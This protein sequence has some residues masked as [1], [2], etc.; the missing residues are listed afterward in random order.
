M[1]LMKQGWL[2][3]VGFSFFGLLIVFFLL[4]KA[5]VSALVAGG[6]GV[7]PANPDPAKPLTQSWFIYELDPGETKEDAVR[8]INN[9]EQTVKLHIDALDGGISQDGGFGIIDDPKNNVD[10]GS[11]IT[12]SETEVTLPPRKEKV[13]KF[14]LTVPSDTYVGDHFGGFGVYQIEEA[15]EQEIKV[16]P[17]ATVKVK[18]RV[19]VRMY[20]TVRGEKI[21]GLKLIR[22]GFSSVKRQL[23]LL[24]G[25]ENKGN[26]KADLNLKASIYGVFGFYDQAEVELGQVAPQRKF[27]KSHPWPGEKAPYF[28]PYLLIG[29]LTD[30]AHS[31]LAKPIRVII[32][33]FFLPLFPTFILILCLFLLWLLY[34]F[35]LWQK[36]L[37]LAR[38]PVA[39]YKIKAG[40]TLNRIA[41]EF[42]LPWKTIAKINNLDA[43]YDLSEIK[44]LYLLDVRG[45]RRTDIKVPSFIHQIGQPFA[46]FG[47]WILGSLFRIDKFQRTRELEKKRREVAKGDL[48]IAR[49]PV[50]SRASSYL[51]AIVEKGDTLASI[52]K[53]F[54]ID[55]KKII[56][57]NN[58]KFPFKLTEGQE[59]KIPKPKQRKSQ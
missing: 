9:S 43:P 28:G 12:L 39:V 55:K 14:T 34:Q 1:K 42:N 40:D 30:T 17:G 36:A 4:P 50:L 57:L 2:K 59:L 8:V 44:Q 52:A 5:P 22:R 26:I 13:I 49:S 45:E 7:L 38:A 31:D 10:V 35:L 29:T 47:A 27:L 37:R 16:A 18:T 21:W 51:T 24:L 25:I 41:S 33:M 53:H 54:Q 32:P 19:G 48:P 58:L 20:L 11:W 23:Y 15:T 46:T 3:R 6:I 56:S